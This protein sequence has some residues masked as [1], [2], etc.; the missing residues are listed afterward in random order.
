VNP[1]QLANLAPP[2][3][4]EISLRSLLAFFR[5][6]LRELLRIRCGLPVYT[7]TVLAPEIPIELDGLG[8][9]HVGDR[10]LDQMRAGGD[11]DTLLAAER[12]SGAL[13]PG[14]LGESVLDK[15]S[16]RVR[17]CL[18]T[19]AALDDA[20]VVRRDLSVPVQGWTLTGSVETVADELRFV[21]FSK[22]TP[23][24]QLEAWLSLLLLQ[25]SDPSTQRR[26]VTVTA[27]GLASW[28]IAGIDPTVHLSRL[29]RIYRLGMSGPIPLPLKT[30][31]SYARDAAAGRPDPL[32]SAADTWRD[33]SRNDDWWG[34]YYAS[35]DELTR[36]SHP[37]DLGLPLDRT[38][39]GTL[40]RTV[41]A[42]ILSGEE[43]YDERA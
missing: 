39:F 5:H 37:A 23:G 4:G 11:F 12:A 7:D 33:E 36:A 16:D 1:W 42:P 38:Y 2:A 34:R 31:F 21:R 30:G 15:V 18:R 41:W 24:V 22:L 14:I 8:Q 35:F 43:R 28:R 20:P 29:L 26:A 25:A 9:W 6:P 19:A 3:P 27:T 40:S 13:P 32:M 10:L 17:E